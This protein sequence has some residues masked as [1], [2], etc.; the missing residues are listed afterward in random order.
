MKRINSYRGVVF[1]MRPTRS[2]GRYIITAHYRGKDIQA[3]TTDAEAYDYYNDDSNMAKHM[4]AVRH[5]YWKVRTAWE[6]SRAYIITDEGSI[7][8]HE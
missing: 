5:C 7:I 2:Y 6:D 3:E 8:R 4:E 1:D